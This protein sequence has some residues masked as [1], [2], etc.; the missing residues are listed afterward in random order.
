MYRKTCDRCYQ[1][2]YSSTKIGKWLCP[3]CNHDLTKRKARNPGDPRDLPRNDYQANKLK[4][5][6]KQL[7]DNPPAI[8]TYI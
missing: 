6:Y 5:R 3:V 7:P 2:S 4:V 8:S 1:L